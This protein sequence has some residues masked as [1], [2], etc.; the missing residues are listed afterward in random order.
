MAIFPANPT[1]LDPYMNFKY[2]L[3][4]DG[5]YVA[6]ISK[7]SSLKRTTEV[8]E[9]REGGDPSTSRKSAGAGEV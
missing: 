5:Q 2:R 4:W 7:C 9:H 8:V 6:G 3:K 1:R